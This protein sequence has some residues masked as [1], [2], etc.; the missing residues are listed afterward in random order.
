MHVVR[1]VRGVN[2]VIRDNG[3]RRGG[4]KLA[5]R[6]INDEDATVQLGGTRDAGCRNEDATAGKAN[7]Q[8]ARSMRTGV[9]EIRLKALSSP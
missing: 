6:T 7:G 5:Q 3:P 9:A 1:K 8:N 4:G 2:V